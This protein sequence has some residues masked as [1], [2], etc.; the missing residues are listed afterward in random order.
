MTLRSCS[1]IFCRICSFFILVS[2]AKGQSDKITVNVHVTFT[3]LV[4]DEDTDLDQKITINDPHI[5]NTT[6]GDKKFWID[7]KYEV[8]GAYFLS[9]LLQ[10]LKLAEEAGKEKITLP[11]GKIFEPPAD[12][13]SRMIREYYWDGLTRRID[14]QGL[15]KILQ[16][17]KTTTAD[18]FHYVYVPRSDKLAFQFYNS[19]TLARSNLRLKVVQLPQEITPAYVREL[20]NYHGILS[21]SLE[22]TKSGKIIGAPFIVPGGRFNEMYGWD[23]YFITLGLLED[24]KLDLAKA[25]ADNFIYEIEQ[26]GKILNAN[27]TYYLTRSQPPFFTSM[28]LAVHEHLP[29]NKSTK[30]WLAR[31][32]NAAINEYNTIWM[33]SDHLTSTGLSRYFDS[34]F[35]PPPEVEAGHFDAAYTEFAKKHGMEMVVFEQAYK[36]GSVHSEE[37]DDYFVHDRAMRESGHDTSYRLEGRCADLVTVDLNSLLYKIETDIAA[38]IQNEFSGTFKTNSGNIERS[39]TWE[40]KAAKRKELVRKYLWN[41]QQGMYFDYNFKEQKQTGY[42]AATTCYPLWA[43]LASKEEADS[44]IKKALPLLEMPGGIAGSTEESRGAI[45]PEHPARQ[46]DYPN[47]WAPHQIL[48]WQ[49]LLNYGYK[50][51][52]ERLAYR[53]LYTITS[54]A[55]NYNGTVPEKFDVATRSHQVFAEYGNVG[56]KFSYITREGFGWTN[57]S[58]Q[59]GLKLL[60]DELKLKL[61]TLIP[62]EWIFLR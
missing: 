18:G 31:A 62:P 42:V 46:W 35:G 54:N 30:L 2:I 57:A 37:M 51:E 47:G 22:K 45:T 39:T 33:N 24:D 12:R 59:I 16:D 61:N 32:L 26:Y 43:K 21:L 48:V 36:N 19:I 58:V 1:Q 28:V 5:P 13:I 50:K 41:E 38:I 25:V 4:V 11:T 27:R 60:S 7:G 9:N 49:G 3:K 17:D 14:E 20:N 8:V 53:W 34:G 52:A 15:I 10:E 23:S 44:L 6:K 40:E 56:T 55:A 29:E